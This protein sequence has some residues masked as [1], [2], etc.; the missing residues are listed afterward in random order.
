MTVYSWVRIQTQVKQLRGKSAY[1][2]TI[3]S[4]QDFMS[5]AMI[6]SM[7]LLIFGNKLIGL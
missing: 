7:T 3:L 4:A 1:L 2:Q 6:N 5:T